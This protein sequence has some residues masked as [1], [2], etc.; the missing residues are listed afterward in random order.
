MGHDGIAR[1][2]TMD[3]ALARHIGNLKVVVEMIQIAGLLR[4]S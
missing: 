1:F 4:E 3:V 2:I